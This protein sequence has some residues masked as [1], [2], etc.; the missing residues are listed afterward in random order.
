M[1]CGDKN[2]LCAGRGTAFACALPPHA[3]SKSG[4][5]RNTACRR[6]GINTPTRLLVSWPGAPKGPVR[7]TL[8]T[9]L[10]VRM[11]FFLLLFLS[12]LSVRA[13]RRPG[14]RAMFSRGA[15]LTVPHWEQIP[16]W[17]L[18]APRQTHSGMT[19]HGLIGREAAAALTHDLATSA[20]LPVSTS[21]PNGHGRERR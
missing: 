12:C 20:G 3:C 10:G 13:G 19:P 2:A 21:K 7:P 8:S 16:F 5:A 14:R 6:T 17:R 9:G 1:E 18:R 15:P 4:V 11:A